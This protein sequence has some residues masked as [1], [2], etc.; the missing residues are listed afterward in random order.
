MKQ[1]SLFIVMLFFIAF[2]NTSNAQGYYFN[3]GQNFTK[4]DY[5]NSQGQR[6]SNLK[7]DNG[8]T[9]DFGYQWIIS[10]NEKWHYKAGLSFQQFNA[11]GQN[12]TFNYS[13]VT[14]YLGIQNGVSYDVYTS[15]DDDFVINLNT[16]FT[17]SKIIKGEQLIN[18]SSYDLTKENEFK[19]LF[20][21]PHL[22]VEN[23]I[24]LNDFAVLGL[25]YRFSKAIRSSTPESESL[26]F[27][28]NA[29]YINFKYLVN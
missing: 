6:N 7:S 11:K 8:I 24:K 22:G 26:N 29:F 10:D 4:Y 3:F 21:Q 18:N 9:V 14:N 20:L 27:I 25:G 16:G 5:K 15:S 13:W 1:I 17:A 28:N 19:G 12:D 2:S 23:E